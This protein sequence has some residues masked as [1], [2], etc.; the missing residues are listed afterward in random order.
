MKKL[1]KNQSGFTLVEIAIVLVII[2]LL[3]GGVLKGQ[4]LIESSKIRG[5]T[6]D[7]NSIQ[8]AWYA[9][10]DRFNSIPGDDLLATTH[11]GVTV[12]NG[13]GNGVIAGAYTLDIPA[14]AGESSN[15]WQHTR[16]A[17][18]L[19]GL[20]SSGVPLTSSTGGRMGIQAGPSG[21][22]GT[23]V[24][25]SID[26]TYAQSIDASLDDGVGTSGE[27]RGGPASATLN[28]VTGAATAYAAPVAANPYLVL[29]RRM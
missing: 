29:C 11:F 10:Q 25:V 14:A 3:L 16:S 19:K 27:V 1:Q 7:M 15:F 9:Y 8:S 20:G 4:A 23:A 28:D 13:G 22:T 2:G 5:V 12:T 17:G 24:C 18:F 6:N 21:L 26:T